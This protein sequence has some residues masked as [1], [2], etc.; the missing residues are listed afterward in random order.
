MQLLKDFPIEWDR[1]IEQDKDTLSVYGWIQ[2]T[3]NKRDFVLL[4]VNV[5]GI[6]LT[7]SS[8]KYSKLMSEKL[9]LGNPSTHTNCIK[10]SEL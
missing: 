6:T 4:G 5:F 2:R 10:V 8:A 1:F 9:N 3:D 7:T